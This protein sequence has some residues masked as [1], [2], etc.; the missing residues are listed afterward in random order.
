MESKSQ[1]AANPIKTWYSYLVEC[2]DGSLYC[3]ITTDLT[4]R[5]NQHNGKLKGGA[6]YTASRR[7]VTL[8]AQWVHDTRSSASQHEYQI[9]QLNRS[10][11]LALLNI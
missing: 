6:K 4:R 7:P 11:K 3:G 1:P 8:K 5:I 2:A 10:D 9:K